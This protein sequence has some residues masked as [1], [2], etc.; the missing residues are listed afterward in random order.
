MGQLLQITRAGILWQIPDL[1]AARHGSARGSA[2]ARQ[3][4]R[5]SRLARAVT[6][7]EAHFVARTHTEGGI[8]EQE[9]RTRAQFEV[10]DCD[11]KDSQ[12]KNAM[13]CRPSQSWRRHRRLHRSAEGGPVK[14]DDSNVDASQ[15]QDSRGRGGG[16]GGMSR[17][18]SYGAGA[19]GLGLIA[20]PIA[21]LLGGNIAPAHLA[22]PL[23]PQSSAVSDV[24]VRCN[25]PGAIEQYDDCYV[26]N[27]SSLETN[28]IWS[29][30][31]KGYNR[32]TPC[33]FERGIR[34]ACGPASSE[35]GPV[36]RPGDAKVY[37]DLGFMKQLQRQ[38]GAE[39]RNA[40]AYIVAH[41]VGH[42]IQN[43]T[44]QERK[45]R[46][47]QQQNPRM[48]NQYSVMLELQADPPRREYG[49]VGPMTPAKSRPPRASCTRPSM[50]RPPWATTGSWPVRGGGP[51]KFHRRTPQQRQEWFQRAPDRR[52][53]TVQHIPFT[54][55]DC[56]PGAHVGDLGLTDPR[57]PL[58]PPVCR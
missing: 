20:S 45:V 18:A 13:T 23:P 46:A 33:F 36:H 30:Q 8:A 56:K 28:E 44:G 41:E 11:H 43:L 55:P 24:A 37:I 34:T 39:G 48:A 7:H 25:Q 22:V 51:S 1:I 58:R 17:G 47:L 15:L 10:R 26:L 12:V 49:P 57:C 19:G 14:F 3:D 2:L 6:P 54:Y 40:Q 42:H 31:V 50:Q 9:A 5:Q 38:L 16:F 52:S 27:T 29:S 21:L 53:R 32:P 4:L 35:T